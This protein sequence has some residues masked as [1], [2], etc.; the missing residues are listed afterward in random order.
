M[1]SHGAVVAREYN[2][3]AV[4]NVPGLMKT[5]QDGQ[6]VTMDGRQGAIWVIPSNGPADV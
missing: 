1:L 3:P 6:L 5:L 4:V 2:L